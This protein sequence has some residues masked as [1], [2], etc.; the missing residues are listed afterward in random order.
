[1]KASDI[2]TGSL[3]GGVFRARL[4]SNGIR[5]AYYGVVF[6]HIIF[7]PL[8]NGKT[9]VNQNIIAQANWFDQSNDYFTT[10]TV[11]FNN[12]LIAIH[13]YYLSRYGKTHIF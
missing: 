9:G 11:R 7:R 10:D 12:R 5:F 4:H 2:I 13:R 8:A 1:M 3:F 6:P